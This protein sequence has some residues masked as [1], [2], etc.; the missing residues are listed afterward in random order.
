MRPLHGKSIDELSI[1]EKWA[2]V[3]TT[4]GVGKAVKEKIMW[5]M[6]DHYKQL[7]IDRFRS[8]HDVSPYW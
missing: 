6:I 4:D 8:D 3:C 5:A 7:A 2:A 1:E